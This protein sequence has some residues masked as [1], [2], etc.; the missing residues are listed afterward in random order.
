MIQRDVSLKR[1]NTFGLDYR[2]SCFSTINSEKEAISFLNDWKSLDE[3]L[4]ILGAGSNLLF[5]KDFEGTII[6]PEIGGIVIEEQKKEFIIISS[7]AGIIW[8]DLVEWTVKQGYGGLENLSLIPGTVG[9][10][11]VQ[12]IGAYGV[13]VRESIE[14]VRTISVSDGS[15]K[16]FSNEEC[17]FSYRNSIF[18]AELKGKYLV[19]RV[20][21]RL[22]TKPILKTDYGSLKEEV[23]KLGPMSQNT[24]RE[25]VIKIRRNK[26]PDP[27]TIG[28]AGS[29]FKNPVVESSVA[30]NLLAIYPDIPYYNDIP[31]HKKISAGWLIDRC[32]WKGKRIGNTGVHDKQAL[33][34]V[35]YGNASGK[36][37]LDLSLE[38]ARSVSDKFGIELQREVEVV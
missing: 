14:K 37:L 16:E 2:A 21:F 28:N 26:L 15:I 6:H 35:N 7:G 32:G 1:Y 3:P 23:R 4:L 31:G 20:F 11:P 38:I 10:S 17:R 34:L 5:I 13:E 9:A 29:F 19:T 24:V 25:A 22:T 30:D 36:E 33:V 27:Q 8:D 12:N 18:K